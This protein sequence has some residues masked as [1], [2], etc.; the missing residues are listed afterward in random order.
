[1]FRGGSPASGFI[2]ATGGTGVPII[3]SAG[4]IPF[5]ALSSGSV[6]AN[7]AISA[8]SGLNAI[9]PNAYC[10]FPANIVATVAAAGWRY[11]T[12]S[13][14]TAGVAF[15]DTYTSG[16]ATIPASPTAVTD[17]KGAFTGEIA[18][19]AGLTITIPPMTAT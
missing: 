8:I 13:S 19:I 1:M 15:L 3:L 18:E 4:G 12:F 6:A 7:G 10:W 11:C 9:Y 2:S 14:T 16:K 17:G 5:I